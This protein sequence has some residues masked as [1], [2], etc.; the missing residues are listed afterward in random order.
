MCPQEMLM[1]RQAWEP[2]KLLAIPWAAI[3]GRD[4]LTVRVVPSLWGL[5]APQ[6]EL[7]GCRFTAGYA[8]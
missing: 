7:G 1:P 3:P 2:S 5:P 8:G 6:P 4:M